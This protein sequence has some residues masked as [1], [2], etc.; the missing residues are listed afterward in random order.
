MC[1]LYCR[2]V[3]FK[4]NSSHVHWISCACLQTSVLIRPV[5]V[6]ILLQGRRDLTQV[7]T[8]PSQASILR[9]ASVALGFRD[10]EMGQ[11]V[12]V[13]DARPMQLWGSH[14]PWWRRTIPRSCFGLTR[15]FQQTLTHVRIINLLFPGKRFDGILLWFVT[16]SLEER[17]RCCLSL[18]ESLS[19]S[20]S[21]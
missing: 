11:N 12:S 15:F 19:Q 10:S 2:T 7:P 13:E 20:R 8:C 17:G 4:P 16:D 3:S 9:S 21:L 18:P 5:T 14:H 1:V 6:D